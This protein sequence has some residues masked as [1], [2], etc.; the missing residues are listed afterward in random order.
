[1]GQPEHP[2]NLRPSVS[3]EHKSGVRGNKATDSETQ[4][5]Q[6]TGTKIAREMGSSIWNEGREV[7]PACAAVRP[8]GEKSPVGGVQCW[9]ERP[10]AV[11]LGVVAGDEGGSVGGE[12]RCET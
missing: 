12:G 11:N 7:S 9:H 8:E 3:E 1:M 6:C 4:H 5:E 2:H 10:D